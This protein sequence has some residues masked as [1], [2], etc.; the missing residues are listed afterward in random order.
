M[1][2][3]LLPQFNT[4]DASKH[5]INVFIEMYGEI[6]QTFGIHVVGCSDDDKKAFQAAVDDAHSNMKLET[7]FDISVTDQKE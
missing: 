7:E 5:K 2:A 3:E 6:I 1:N 4:R